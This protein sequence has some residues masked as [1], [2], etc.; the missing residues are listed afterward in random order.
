[1][2]SAETSVHGLGFELVQP[3]EGP[4]IYHDILNQKGEGFHHLACMMHTQ[5]ESD[6]L[7]KRFATLGARVLMGGR[8][9]ETIEFLYFDTEPMLKIIIESG[10]GHAIDLKPDRIYP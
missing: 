1:M 3:L 5:E 2:R 6:Q 9:G 8:I 10:S 7:K 4:S